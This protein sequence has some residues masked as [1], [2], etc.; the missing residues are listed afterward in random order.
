MQRR[1]Q[2][3][4]ITG[5]SSGIGRACA[6]RFEREGHG[7]YG[8]SRDFERLPPPSGDWHPLRMDVTDDASVRQAVAELLRLEGRVDVVISNA[9]FGV[10]GA[11]EDTAIAE[12]MSQ[13]DVNLFGALRVI[14]AA[15]PAMRNQ[16]DGVIIQIGSLAGRIAVPCQGLYSASKHAVEAL[17]ETLRM[18]VRR[19]GVRVVLVEPG[20]LRTAFTENRVRVKASG[21][22]SPYASACGRALNRAETDERSG[23][24]AEAVARLVLRVSALRSPRLRY[25]AGPGLQRFAVW[26]RK[27]LPDRVFEALLVR[28]YGGLG[29]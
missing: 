25:T 15:L 23:G 28:Y 1:R 2:V 12:A 13:F 22:E 6:E 7:V 27:L 3:V 16:R 4:L 8:T 29:R 9:G 11:V 18:E 24:S 5:A 19:F 17:L 10:A 21:E 14:R 26:L 20:D